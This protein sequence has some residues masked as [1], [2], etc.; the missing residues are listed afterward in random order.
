VKKGKKNP[1]TKVYTTEQLME[2]LNTS[3]GGLRALIYRMKQKGVDVEPLSKSNVYT[4]EDG[5][6]IIEAARGRRGRPRKA[7][8]GMNH[9]YERLFEHL[10]GEKNENNDSKL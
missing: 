6:K 7:D 5:Q 1:P 10:R 8:K 2:I 4:V 9:I 3:A